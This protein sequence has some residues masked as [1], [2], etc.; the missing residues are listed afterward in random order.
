[1]RIEDFQLYSRRIQ[2]HLALGRV[3]PRAT[4]YEIHHKAWVIVSVT[5]LTRHNSESMMQSN[6]WFQ[7]EESIRHAFRRIYGGKLTC[8]SFLDFQARLAESDRSFTVRYIVMYP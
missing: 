8:S 3:F 7:E 5:Y 1:M 6:K 2:D 4:L